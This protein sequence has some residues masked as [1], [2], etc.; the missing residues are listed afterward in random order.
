[1]SK[2][3][4][5]NSARLRTVLTVLAWFLGVAALTAGVY[6]ARAGAPFDHNWPANYNLTSSDNGVLF[7]LAHDVFSGFT[8]DWSFSPQ[9]YIFPE[10]PI[11]LFAYAITGGSLAWYYLAIAV[12]NV[13][14]LFAT[15]WWLA[16]L[17]FTESLNRQLARAFIA[18]SPMI[19]LPLVAQQS[20]YLFQLAPTYYYGMYLFG[21]M[22]PAALLARQRW[23]RVLVLAG[24][25]LTGAADPLLFAMT[26]PGVVVVAAIVLIRGGWRKSLLPSAATI[27]GALFAALIVRFVLFNPIAGT[28]PTNY[29]SAERAAGRMR[30]IAMTFKG[31]FRADSDPWLL[32]LSILALAACLLLFVF[33]LRDTFTAPRGGVDRRL[34]ARIYLSTLPFFGALAMTVILAVHIYYLWFGVV[35]SIVVAG[36]LLPRSRMVLP[37]AGAL[38]LLTAIASVISVSSTDYDATRYFGYQSEM[39]ACLDQSVPGQTGYSTFSD[40]RSYG[41]TS[42]SGVHLIAVNPDLSPNF[43][44]TNRAYSKE[45]VGTFILLNPNTA[46]PPLQPAVV[47]EAWGEPEQVLHCGDAVIWTYDSAESQARLTNWFAG[48]QSLR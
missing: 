8:L 43:W 28:S 22:L 18:T 47:R 10:I 38:A 36:L 14:L 5:Q 13:L 33:A 12:I 46:E 40:S 26:L 1:M 31:G 15:L 32:A 6:L 37:I 4:Q 11:S 9:V 30:E 29:I 35:G 23:A 45:L 39:S 41:L 34:L 7:Q 27:A 17:L 20:M 25:A 48:Y 24:W 21:I 16:R 42:Q 44:L 19:L 3:A 2:T